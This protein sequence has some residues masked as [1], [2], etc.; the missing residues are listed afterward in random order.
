MD[1]DEIS[2]QIVDAAYRLHV[3]LG[4]GLLESIYETVL[5]RDL[6]RRG[7]HVERRKSISFHYDG[8]HFKDCLRIDLSVESL[9]IVEIKSVERLHPMHSKQLLTYL[10][11]SNL[12]IGLLM[13]FGAA[14]MKDGLHR[15]VNKFQ[16]SASSRLRVNQLTANTNDA[17]RN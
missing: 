16:P 6:N 4:S 9:V 8:L 17:E 2:G 5:V 15:V 3:G 7:L 14:T 10:R 11:L 1:P 12:P 13:N